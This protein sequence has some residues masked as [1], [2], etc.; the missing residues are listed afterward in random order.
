[1]VLDGIGWMGSLDIISGWFFFT[2]TLMGPAARRG[3]PRRG[4]FLLRHILQDGHIWSRK[5]ISGPDFLKNDDIW[6]NFI[7][8]DLEVE[9][10]HPEEVD[11]WSN[12]PTQKRLK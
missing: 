5:V 6:S 11:I 2:Q 1:M 7:K 8:L 10:G 4:A 9:K 12:W 3:I